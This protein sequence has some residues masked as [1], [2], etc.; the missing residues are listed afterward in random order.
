VSGPPSKPVALALFAWLMASG[1]VLGASS[2]RQVS[3]LADGVY[4]IQH[5]DRN[6]GNASGNT[7]VIIG[8]R[9]V[10]V[11]DSGYRPSLAREDI[12]QIRQWTDK[13]VGF[14]VITHFH[15]DHN[16]GSQAYLEAFPALAIVAQQET[17]QDMDLIQPGNI[18]RGPKRLAAMIAAFKQGQDQ[19]GR[20]LS[21]DDKK[22]VATLLPG[23]EQLLAES[24]TLAYQPPTLTFSDRLDIELGNRAVQ[25]RHL[26]RGNTPGD[27][28]V[29]L[30]KE[31]IVVAGDLLVHPI[32]YTYDGYPAEW[33]QTLHELAQLDPETIVPGHGPV[34][35]GTVY[36]HLVAEL[37]TSAVEQ[38]RA[39]VRQIGHPG[40]HTLDEVAGAVDLTPFRA[41]FAGADEELQAEFDRMAAQLVKLVYSEAAQR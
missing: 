18:E 24:R 26:G 40:F 2:P 11:V 15:N 9:V 22:E 12:A 10:L 33:A 35:R 31:K 30:P 1:P 3:R 23:L 13:P 29:H 32:P 20:E 39:R 5:A 14:L 37:F 41:R 19:Q 27:T 38:V 25:V 6:D 8:E 16:N 28:I 17:R 21:E 36:L 7:T 34:L 4:A